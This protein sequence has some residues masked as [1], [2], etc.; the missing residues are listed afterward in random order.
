MSS[1]ILRSV[2]SAILMRVSSAKHP[3]EVRHASYGNSS[4]AIIEVLHDL[5]S[6]RLAAEAFS[7]VPDIL[8]IDSNI[9][10]PDWEDFGINA[11]ADMGDL[12]LEG[13]H[14]GRI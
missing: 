14:E 4:E 10:N 1:E 2:P 8:G 11:F 6:C 5:R 13:C 3:S 9:D 7:T 12:S